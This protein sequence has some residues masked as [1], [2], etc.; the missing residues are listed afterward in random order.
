MEWDCVSQLSKVSNKV[1]LWE[2]LRFFDSLYWRIWPS[3]RLLGSGAKNRWLFLKRLYQRC[4]TKT[5]F[6]SE[7][8]ETASVPR[9]NIFKWS[10]FKV[11]REKEKKISP[12]KN[13]AAKIYLFI[14]NN[15]NTRKTCEICSK[16]TIKTPKRRQWHRSGIFIVNFEHISPLF[17]ALL[18]LTLKIWIL[19]GIYFLLANTSSKLIVKALE[20]RRKS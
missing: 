10:Q 18:Y 8:P 13:V 6:A 20:Q 5:K 14:V 4:L 3:I 17:L 15:K 19:A 7:N 12:S 1:L 11:Q 16:V 2:Q 9:N